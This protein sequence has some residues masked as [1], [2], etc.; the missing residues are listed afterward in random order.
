MVILLSASNISE[1]PCFPAGQ[2]GAFV[3]FYESKVHF[4][5]WAFRQ[6]SARGLQPWRRPHLIGPIKW[7]P[8][9][10]PW[11]VLWAWSA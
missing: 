1:A 9:S 7:G 11:Q 3:Q 4:T 10:K 2:V 6:L 8:G 5:L